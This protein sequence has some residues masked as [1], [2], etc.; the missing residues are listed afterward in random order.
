M[1]GA[2]Q[3]Y[4]ASFI[5]LTLAGAEALLDHAKAEAVRRDLRLCMAVVDA[6]GH[7]LAFSRMDGAGLVSIEV[8]LGKARTAAFLQAPSRMFEE[9]VDG[10]APSILSVS[11][12]VPLRGGVPVA[13][14]GRIVGALGISGASGE[15][16]EAVALACVEA[17]GQ[18]W[19]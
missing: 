2:A 13:S 8:A 1:S 17:F 18:H 9:K 12:L 5:G 4:L 19:A 11:Q 6:S 3:P 14:G 15:V 7:L 16:D 10:G